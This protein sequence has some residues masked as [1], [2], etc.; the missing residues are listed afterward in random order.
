MCW[1]V[2]SGGL[3]RAAGGT[4]EQGRLPSTHSCLV[5]VLPV[6]SKTPPH[7]VTGLML[8]DCNSGV[9]WTILTSSMAAMLSKGRDEIKIL[10]FHARPKERLCF[11]S[12]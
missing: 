3:V 8:N 7:A 1:L 11:C 12:L 5:L 6:G 4:A 10:V 2:A 9:A